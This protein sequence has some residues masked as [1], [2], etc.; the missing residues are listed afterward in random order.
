MLYRILLGF[1]SEDYY[2]ISREEY[3]KEEGN[4]DY[5]PAEYFS[6]SPPGIL[7]YIARLRMPYPVRVILTTLILLVSRTTKLVKLIRKHPVQ[8]IIACTGDVVDIPSAFIAS[9]ILGIDFYAYILDDYVY[10]WAGYHRSFAKAI[11]PWIFKRSTGLIGLN[12]YSCAEYI[13]RYHV[14]CL[15]VRN[16][17]TMDTLTAPINSEWPLQ[18]GKIKI[19]YTGSIYHANNDCFHNLIMA[20][21]VL[22]SYGVE[23]HIYTDQTVEQL[24][25]QGVLSAKVHIHPQILDSE[26]FKV[27]RDADIL[28]LPLAFDSLIPEVIRTSSPNKMGEYLAS[29]SPVL[30][31]VPVDSF[32]AYYFK[33]NHCGVIVGESNVDLLCECIKQIIND[34]ELRR[35]VIFNARACSVRD[36]NPVELQKILKDFLGMK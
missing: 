36:F 4:G 9:K 3:V 19:V 34:V 27:Q 23:L 33:K 22:E 13:R 16:P 1:A 32:V 18:A 17:C 6:V 20:M 15:M 25:D 12:E 28:F 8:A 10:Q 29:G 26:V 24:S 5:L 31:H 11:S 30:A 35:N 2:L 14:D 7:R 21:D